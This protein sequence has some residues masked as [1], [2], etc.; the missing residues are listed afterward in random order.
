MTKIDKI[1]KIQIQVLFAFIKASLL[2]KI[3]QFGPFGEEL[4]LFEA[5]Y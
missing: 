5:N 3:R 4:K 1:S 2:Q